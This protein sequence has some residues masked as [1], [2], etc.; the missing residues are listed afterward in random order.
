MNFIK[1]IF[2]NKEDNTPV[3]SNSDFW[4]WFQK[5]ERTFHNVVK[6]R[7]DIEGVFFD[8]LSAKLE[9]L[10]EGYY[11]L[12]GMLDANTVELVLTADG[13]IKNLVFVEELVR[14]APNIPGWKFTAHKA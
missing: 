7:G 11:Y 13:K 14:A 6:K 9:E 4:N 10:R 3:R 5:N 8:K 1:K 2:G 12:T